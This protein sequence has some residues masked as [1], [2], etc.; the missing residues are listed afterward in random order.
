MGFIAKQLKFILVIIIVIFLFGIAYRM[1]P[2]LG[3]VN[4]EHEI[5]VSG[6]YTYAG[7]TTPFEIKSEWDFKP[8]L[9]ED[10]KTTIIKVTDEKQISKNQFKKVELTLYIKDTK[11][12]V[13]GT[14]IDVNNLVCDISRAAA[15]YREVLT[16][17]EGDDK[18][19]KVFQASESTGWIIIDN[20]EKMEGTF[21]LFLTD[22]SEDNVSRTIEL[23]GELKIN[24]RRTK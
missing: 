20:V 1:E 13:E 4:I 9:A 17:Y 8:A 6:D 21:D 23:D 11:S 22:T 7:K 5:V 15:N 19:E 3:L 10:G 12:I 18:T 2:R 16:T 24:S 14:K